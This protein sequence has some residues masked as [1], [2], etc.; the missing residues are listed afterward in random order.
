MAVVFSSFLPP[1]PLPPNSRPRERFLSLPRCRPMAPALLTF[2]SGDNQPGKSV[3]GTIVSR[4]CEIDT[5]H[6]Q[7]SRVFLSL[8][9]VRLFC[10]SMYGSNI[11]ISRSVE[12]DKN[13]D[14]PTPCT[15]LQN[16]HGEVST[17]NLRC[18]WKAPCTLE[19]LRAT[20]RMNDSYILLFRSYILQYF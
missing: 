11:T 4:F 15:S 5:L 6:T 8:L 20:N 9:L 14:N 12:E 19:H 3:A 17:L 16:L 1:T 18:T 13:C 7:M 2:P 10:R